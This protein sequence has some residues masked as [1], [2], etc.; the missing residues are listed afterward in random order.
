MTYSRIPRALVAITS[1]AAVLAGITYNSWA[2]TGVGGSFIGRGADPGDILAPTESA[3]V[4][5]QT[6]WNNIDSGTTFK[7]TSAPMVDGAGNF[8]AVRGLLGCNE[9]LERAGGS[10][11]PGE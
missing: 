6:H 10:P 9:R 4:F 3:G 1:A 11:T 8:T 2:A 7:G 5:P